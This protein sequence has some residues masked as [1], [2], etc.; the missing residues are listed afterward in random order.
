MVDWRASAEAHEQATVDEKIQK[1]LLLLKGRA[2]VSG[3]Y[4]RVNP[5]LDGFWVD[6]PT[7]GEFWSLID[8]LER[9]GAIERKFYDNEPPDGSRVPDSVALTV[10]G[11]MRVG[12]DTRGDSEQANSRTVTPKQQLWI[13]KHLAAARARNGHS[14]ERAAEEI[15]R[16]VT[17]LDPA[18]AHPEND[19]ISSSTVSRWERGTTPPFKTNF[20]AVERYINDA[21]GD[22]VPKP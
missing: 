22:S 1:L 11:L 7:G 20:P 15:G 5:D 14:L 6:T 2:R 10:D 8:K 12:D 19:V 18:R 21:L 9:G 16:I 4:V 17:E 3:N 13:T